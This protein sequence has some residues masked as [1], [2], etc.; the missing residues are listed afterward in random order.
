MAGT[1]VNVAYLQHHDIITVIIYIDVV[2]PFS[3]IYFFV[4]AALIQRRR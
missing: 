4:S 1:D 2:G 3:Y